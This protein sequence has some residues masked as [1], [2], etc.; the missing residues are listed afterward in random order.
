MLSH[1]LRPC[2]EIGITLVEVYFSIQPPSV[3]FLGTNAGAL[4]FAVFPLFD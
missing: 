3:L 1:V 4:G 2:R